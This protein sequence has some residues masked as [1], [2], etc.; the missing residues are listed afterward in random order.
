MFENLIRLNKIK[1][2]LGKRY[3]FKESDYKDSYVFLKRLEDGRIFYNN[4]IYENQEII[5]L[6]CL[7]KR[8]FTRSFSLMKPIYLFRK[9]LNGNIFF[10]FYAQKTERRKSFLLA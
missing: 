1:K 4:Q 9:S 6:K 2:K 7:K 10:F 3:S 8:S 5:K